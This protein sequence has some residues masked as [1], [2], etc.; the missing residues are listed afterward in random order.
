MGAPERSAQRFLRLRR[1]VEAELAVTLLLPPEARRFLEDYPQAVGSSYE[2]RV[3]GSILADFYNA[4][5]RVFRRIAEELNGGLPAGADWHATLLSDMALDL[6]GVRPAVIG[7]ALRDRLDE[8]LRTRH[9]IRHTYGVRL[10][11][12]RLR[13]LAAELGPLVVDFD[14]EVRDFLAFVDGLAGG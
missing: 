1:E 9:L 2:A 4:V 12:E 10:R 7:A 3:L 14:G 5:E 8:Y 6:P 13:E 11:G